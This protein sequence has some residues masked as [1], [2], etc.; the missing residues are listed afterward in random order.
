[1]EQTDAP[2]SKKDVTVVEKTAKKLL[3]TLGIEATLTAATNQDTI[4]LVLE[5]QDSGVVIGYHGEALESLQLL[6]ALA[7]SKK[8]GRF[9]RV[10]LEVGDYKKNRISWLENLAF[11]AKEE[12]VAKQQEVLLP[13]LK[14]WERR[15]VHM[16]LADDKDIVSESVGEGRDRTLVV[17]PRT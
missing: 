6:I 9:I 15:I 17:K 12:A 7:A 5:T 13:S 1:M 2:L 8:I 3:D 16:Y 10:S 11:S 4:E 14:S